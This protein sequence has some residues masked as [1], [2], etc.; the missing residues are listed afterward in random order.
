[1]HLGV[2]LFLVW[3]SHGYAWKRGFWGSR[4]HQWLVPNPEQAA[5][6]LAPSRNFRVVHER[7]Y[8]IS[9]DRYFSSW[10]VLEKKKLFWCFDCSHG[11]RNFNSSQFWLGWHNLCLH[12]SPYSNQSI[13]VGSDQVFLNHCRTCTKILYILGFFSFLSWGL[14]RIN[15]QT[16]L[17]IF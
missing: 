10:M 14:S 8:P 6:T 13:E 1:M 3:V 9:F 2:S 5:C 15:C 7:R 11:C 17:L 4:H 16:F 12:L